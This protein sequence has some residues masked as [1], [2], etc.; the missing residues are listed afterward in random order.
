MK[1]AFQRFLAITLSALL[2]V[3]FCAACQEESGDGVVDGNHFYYADIVVKDYGTIIVRLEPDAAPVTVQNFIN[4]AKSGFYDGLTFHRIIA[5]FMI[6]GGDPL[7]NGYGGSETKIVGEF[8]I[9]GYDNPISHVRGVIS[10]ARSK[11]PNS[12]SCQFFIVHRDSQPSLDGKYAAFGYVIE[13]MDVVDEICAVARPID[14]NGGI[15]P[16]AQPVIESI[17]IRAV[18]K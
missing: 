11:D 12:A 2:I 16:S 17:T 10:M 15:A 14:G 13:G 1:H 7:G 5:G 18:S 3:S 9:N 4:L 6:Q 8:A